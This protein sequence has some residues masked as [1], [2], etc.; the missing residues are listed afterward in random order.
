MP[1]DVL[2]EKDAL[3][4]APFD[5]CALMKARN[6]C[7]TLIWTVLIPL[8]KGNSAHLFLSCFIAQVAS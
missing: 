4:H 2:E 1:V 7:L 8:P 5:I 6:T 3:V